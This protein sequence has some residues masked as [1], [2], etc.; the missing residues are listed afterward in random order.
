M[1]RLA[2]AHQK[3]SGTILYQYFIGADGTILQTNPLDQSVDLTQPWPGQA[4]NIAIAGDFTA[5]VPT[6]AQLAAAGHLSAW[7]LQELKLPVDA[8][9]G[10]SE[11]IPTQSPGTQWLQG[12]NWKSL[13]LT[14]IADVQKA[15]DRVRRS[16]VRR[17]KLSALKSASC[18][19]RS[20][21][22][23]PVSPP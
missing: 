7:L 6:D 4:V 5:Q 13:L 11:L 19:K 17:C 14:R 12:L 15:R 1:D 20:A 9:K 18:S 21:W 23:R 22:R 3:R 8:V 2:A 10:A 16:T